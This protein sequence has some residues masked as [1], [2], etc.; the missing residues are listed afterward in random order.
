MDFSTV[1]RKRVAIDISLRG[2]KSVATKFRRP[3]PVNLV[4]LG[5]LLEANY[6][7]MN[8]WRAGEQLMK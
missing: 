4:S 3:F 7:S 8:R 2:L 1:S 5:L 6:C